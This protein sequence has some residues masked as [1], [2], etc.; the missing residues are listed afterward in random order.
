MKNFLAARVF[1]ARDRPACGSIRPA[2]VEFGLARV[3]DSLASVGG[4]VLSQDVAADTP[5]RTRV[6]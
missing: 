1:F 5:A 4:L 6:L 2:S 3:N